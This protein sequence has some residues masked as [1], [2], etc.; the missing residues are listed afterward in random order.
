MAESEMTPLFLI[1]YVRVGANHTEVAI[2]A[3]DLA[4]GQIQHNAI[5]LMP[6]TTPKSLSYGFHIFNPIHQL[7]TRFGVG[8]SVRQVIVSRNPVLASC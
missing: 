2:A 3:I 8:L 4:S 6:Q 1:Q 5:L 7:A